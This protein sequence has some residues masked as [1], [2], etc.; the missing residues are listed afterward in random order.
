MRDRRLLPVEPEHAGT[1]GGVP[2]QS[3]STTVGPRSAARSGA[4]PP[5]GVRMKSSTL[6]RIAAVLLVLF[7]FG[8]TLGFTQ[9][10]GMAGADT[11]VELMKKVQFPVQGFQRSY[12]SFYVGFG[13]FVTIFLLFSAGLSW[14]LAGTPREVR[15]QIPAATWGLAICFLCVAILSWVY[16]FAVPGIFATLITVCLGIAAARGRMA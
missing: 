10:T 1:D 5:K 11:V 13:L 6:Y 12:W 9:T 7:A 2:G 4:H 3:V 15:L 8:H 14:A 16:F